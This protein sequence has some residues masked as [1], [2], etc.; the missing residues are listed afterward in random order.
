MPKKDRFLSLDLNLLK[1]FLVL[2]RELNMRKASEQL[3]ISQPAISQSLLKLRHHFDDE[4]FVKVRTG[5]QPTPFSIELARKLSPSFEQLSVT[6]NE[7]EPFDPSKLDINIRIAV[8][9]VILNV[10]AVKLLTRMKSFAPKCTLELVTSSHSTL[11]EVENGEALLSYGYH[12]TKTSKS[13]HTSEIAIARG[14]V[15][16]RQNHPIKKKSITPYEFNNYEFASFVIPGWNGKN[17]PTVKTLREHGVEPK[18]HFRSDDLLTC[19]EMLKTSNLLMPMTDLF[20]I[21]NFPELKAITA[22]VQGKPVDI[23]IVCFSHYKNRN[24]PL[25]VWINKLVSEILEEQ[26]QTYNNYQLSLS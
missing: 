10:L 19:L 15:V 14:C 1:T 25:L 2:S 21:Q 13:L 7:V 6:L 5:L 26:K 4:L 20:P 8:S 22:E 18:V 16:M 17:S 12:T 23:P 24:A 9:P 11:T 3:C